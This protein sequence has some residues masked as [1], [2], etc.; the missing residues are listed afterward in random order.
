MHFVEYMKSLHTKRCIEIILVGNRIEFDYHIGTDECDDRYLPA[1]DLDDIWELIST[2]ESE[3]AEHGDNF[4]IGIGISL[5]E[6]DTITSWEMEFLSQLL[7]GIPNDIIRYF[8][9]DRE[10]EDITLHCRDPSHFEKFNLKHV[11]FVCGSR[12][13]SAR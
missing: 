2:I 3:I 4:T 6:E 11:K 9:E 13:K 12:A 8:I 7:N 5:V 10:L 1:L